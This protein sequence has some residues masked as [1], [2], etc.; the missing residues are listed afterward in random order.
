MVG[1]LA[2]TSRPAPWTCSGPDGLGQRLL[3]DDAAAGGVDDPDARLGLGQQ[4]LADQAE[5]L[6]VLRQVDGDEVGLG[7]QLVEAH[8]LDAHVL[9]PVGGDEGVVGH[10]PHAEGQGPLGHQGADPAQADHAQGLAVQ[11]DPLPLG[12]LPLAGHQGGVG[13]GDVAGLGQQQGHGL[14][15]GRQD[16]G[17]GGVDHHHPALGGRGHVDVVEA[18]A[19]PA[20]HHQVG[21]GREH[22]GGDRGGR[23]DDQGVGPDDGRRP[24][25]RGTVRAGRRPRGRRRPSGPGPAGPASR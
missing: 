18:D 5:G 15:G 21:A 7:H 16:V 6:G 4:V 2:N 12:A 24:A 22:L 8:Q 11:L 9:G 1:S 19:G 13:L 25:P 3:V 14:L 17:L 20:H 10:Q 23:A